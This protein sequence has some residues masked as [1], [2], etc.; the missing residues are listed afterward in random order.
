VSE[1]A[2]LREFYERSYR[3]AAAHGD[4]LAQWRALGAIGK[5]DHV[6][7]LCAQLGLQPA[8]VLEVGCG[9]GALLAELERRRF[10]PS[11]SGFEISEEAAS[12]ARSRGLAVD[13]FDGSQLPAADLSH[14][15]GLLSHVLEHVP[16]PAGLLRETARVCR[17]VIVEVPLE[18][19]LS[20]RRTTKRRGAAEIGHLQSL[21]R[22]AVRELVESAGLRVT[23]EL[24]DPLPAEVHLFFAETPAARIR[25]R[26][27]AAVRRG[28][29][30][31]SP[32]LATR[33]FTLHYACV[34]V[35][36]RGAAV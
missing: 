30:V 14:D 7:E 33:L 19:N 8:T 16:D 29:F 15:L 4:R 20:A 32:P 1:A 21:D 22:E 5:A 11:L 6:Q 10:A 13:V 23:G 35:R 36:P 24:L 31:A 9:D 2:H 3:D 25:A 17:S 12:I 26:A 18:A 34:C 27:K 28:V